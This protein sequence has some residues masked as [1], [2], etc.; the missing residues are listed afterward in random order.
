MAPHLVS[1]RRLVKALGGLGAAA[2]AVSAVACTPGTEESGSGGA[3]AAAA[4]P[5]TLRMLYATAEADAAAV[6]SLKPAFKQKFGFDL[7]IDTQPYDALQQ[8]VFSEF[9]SNSSY[10]DIVIVDTP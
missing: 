2:L 10:Y 4:K 6:Q 3:D 9:A 5:A 7:Q 8:K 1:R